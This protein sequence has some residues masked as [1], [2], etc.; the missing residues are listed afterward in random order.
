MAKTLKTIQKLLTEAD[1]IYG[2]YNAAC[3]DVCIE[4]QK[5]VD[6]TE[7]R[8]EYLPGDGL[9]FGVVEPYTTDNGL[10]EIAIDD[11]V[12]VPAETFFNIVSEKGEVSAEDFYDSK[13]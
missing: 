1:S 9:C 12:L 13:I 4:A 3:T 5:Y 8:W 2:K 11:M 6:W 10:V 7:L